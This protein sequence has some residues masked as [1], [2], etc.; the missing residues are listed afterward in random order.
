ELLVA[1]ERR[2]LTRDAL[3]QVAIAGDRVDEVV[4]G[5]RARRG[6]RV[7]QAA[8]VASGV[9]EAHGR[10]EALAERPR[11]DLDASGVTVLRVAGRLGAPRAQR[12]DVVELE[13]VTT[14]VELDV[15]G[16][17]GVT[18]RED[19]AVATDPR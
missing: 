18:D 19:E 14:E 9:G 13:P 3:L 11:G 17:R 6:S 1:G 12:L 4:E 5:A 16:Q 2:R 8:L 15:L 10:S 7:E